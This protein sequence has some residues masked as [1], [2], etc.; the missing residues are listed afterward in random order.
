MPNVVWV[1]EVG[2]VSSLEAADK[3]E[4]AS[5]SR[6]SCRRASALDARSWS[7]GGT[8]R[9]GTGSFPVQESEI[10]ERSGRVTRVEESAPAAMAASV[11]R[12]AFFQSPIFLAFAHLLRCRSMAWSFWD[13]A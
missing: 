10:F 3:T 4:L 8:I 5:L 7:I 1:D 12:R 6:W 13:S 2:A 11:S 9:S